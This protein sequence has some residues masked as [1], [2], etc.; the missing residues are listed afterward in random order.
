MNTQYFENGEE[1]ND[2]V[3][4]S[5]Y[6]KGPKLCF[7]VVFTSTKNNIY[8]YS[9]RYNQTTSVSDSILG[10]EVGIFNTDEYEPIDELL[11]SPT[12]FQYEF[13]VS[14]FVQIQN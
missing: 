9:I 12:N 14:G 10:D 5:D 6:E 11:I 4:S 3:T 1:I 2:Y 13:M 7:A 8:E